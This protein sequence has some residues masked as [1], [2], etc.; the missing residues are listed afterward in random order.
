MY[1]IVKAN[2]NNLRHGTASVKDRSEINKTTK[3]L[4]RQKGTG[5]ARH[6]ARKS[7]IFVGGASTHGPRPRSYFEKVNKKLK[8][9]GYQEAFKYLI[10]NDHLKVLN[11]LNF[12]KPNTQ[13]A[14]KTLGKLNLRKALVVLTKDNT[15]ARLSFR[16]LKDVKVISDENINVYDMLRYENVVVTAESFE[17]IKERYTL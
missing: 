14:G 10:Q 17:K 5:N 4:Y 15:N 7:N 6:G 3:K 16:N 13:E 9:K 12:D 1:Y 11:E 8:M 2:R